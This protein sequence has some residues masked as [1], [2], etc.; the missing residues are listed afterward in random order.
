MISIIYSSPSLLFISRLVFNVMNGQTGILTAGIV[1]GN[2]Q[3]NEMAFPNAIISMLT[4][5]G[6]GANMICGPYLIE[7]YNIT[8]ELFVCVLI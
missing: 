1:A 5:I 3:K 2:F 6:S 4:I 7:N 8:S